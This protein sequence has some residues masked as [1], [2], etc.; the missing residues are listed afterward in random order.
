MIREKLGMV[1][2]VA[3]AA[4]I[5]R[6]L[7]EVIFDWAVGPIFYELFEAGDFLGYRVDVLTLTQVITAGLLYTGY[8]SARD[9][10]S[11]K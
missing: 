8:R 2:D 6:A 11:I 9:N 10:W 4:L 5:G 1:L 7:G 3:I